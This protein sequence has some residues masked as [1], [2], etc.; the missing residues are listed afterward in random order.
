MWRVVEEGISSVANSGFQLRAGSPVH[1]LCGLPWIMQ[2]LGVFV[3][4]DFTATSVGLRWKG[5]RIGEGVQA[6]AKGIVGWMVKV[7][8]S[9]VFCA[10]WCNDIICWDQ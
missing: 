9:A 5:F 6:V 2:Y 4:H 3:F 7:G 10:F 8:L 1:V